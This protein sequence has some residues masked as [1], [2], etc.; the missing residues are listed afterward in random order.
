[1]A[2]NQDSERTKESLAIRFA[3]VIGIGGVV[4]F[5][6]LPFVAVLSYWI[7]LNNAASE[8]KIATDAAGLV[9][10]ADGQKRVPLGDFTVPYR[11]AFKTQLATL[12]LS[13]S[14]PLDN[15]N[16]EKEIQSRNPELTTIAK[17]ILTENG[18]SELETTESRL[19]LRTALVHAMNQILKEGQIDVLIFSNITAE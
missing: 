15:E 4:I 2:Q 13:I 5:L 17:S 10:N 7:A 11:N 16:L 3:I 14:I 12:S 1:M 8:N 6:V 18:W 19:A 9:F